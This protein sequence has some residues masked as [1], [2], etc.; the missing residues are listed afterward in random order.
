[1]AL[2]LWITSMVCDVGR[3]VAGLWCGSP[4]RRS[5]TLHGWDQVR[6]RLT[7]RVG[8]VNVAGPSQPAPRGLQAPELGCD[9]TVLLA[10]LGEER[11]SPPAA[12]C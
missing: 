6:A 5:G 7:P 2:P 1:V 9:I 3:G 8:W 12:P 10:V 4:I 11:S